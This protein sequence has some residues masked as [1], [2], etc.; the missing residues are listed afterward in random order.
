[1][2]CDVEFGY[3][4]KIPP[5]TDVNLIKLNST[6]VKKCKFIPVTGRGGP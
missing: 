2:Q 5:K 3:Q 1:M 6:K 4:L